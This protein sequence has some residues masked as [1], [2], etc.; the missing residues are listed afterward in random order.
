MKKFLYPILT[1]V[2]MTI[3]IFVGNGL[4]NRASAQ[5]F[6]FRTTSSGTKV[7]ELLRYMETSYVDEL[8]MD[9]I[10]DE[11]MADIISRLDPHSAYIPKKDLE[12]VNSELDGSFS[13]VGIQFSIQNDTIN[14][15]AVIN[16]GP[17]AGVGILPGDKIIMVDDSLFVGK[18]INNERV[19]HTLRGP[20]D[21]HVKLSIKRSGVKDLLHYD[22]IRG[23]IP[24]HTVDAKFMATD[25][26]GFIYV[27]KF[28][29]TTY[30][31]FI[32]ALAELKAQGA[33]S[34]I[35]DLRSNSGGYMDQA[36]R[37]ANEFL[38]RGDLIVYAEGRA[39][40]RY[41]ARA[42]GSGRFKDVP[43][44]VLVDG[45]SASASE[46][47]SGAMQDN[48]RATIIGQRTFGK[49][50]VQQQYTL[51]DSSAIRLTI[52]RYYMPSGRSIQKPYEL[53]Q[54]EDYS[55]ELMER[56]EHGEFYSADS[57]HLKDSTEYF[58]KQGRRVY[59][60]GGVMPDIFVGRDTILYT[61]YY[62]MCVNLAV[63]YQ[64][65]LH[66]ANENRAKLNKYDDW[67]SLE[68][69]LLRANWLPEFVQFA[70]KKGVEPNAKELAKS[71]PLLIRLVNAYI[72]RNIL[73]DAGFYPLYER[74]DIVT[75]RAIEA[76]SK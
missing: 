61:P 14:I 6:W 65:A 1:V 25:K 44:V 39:Y 41:D 72:V 19:M 17:S 33:T 13:G 27:S 4:A 54:G 2:F 34:Y 37:M 28:G 15:V 47:F 53:G 22:V 45:F 23:D 62:N 3:G 21:T 32:Q 20:K 57:I 52:A 59:G 75:Q 36:I 73:D 66:Y 42:T 38:D 48:D 35:I 46:I 49:G 40:P 43:L 56:F 70:E 71:K 69:Y 50:L 76:L 29:A 10:T 9:S 26:I 67:Q 55:K 18:S 12:I 64:F 60:G 16:G 24:L 31:E 11:V 51:S 7:D 58:T 68:K 63:T 30:S 5:Q 8:N 74:D